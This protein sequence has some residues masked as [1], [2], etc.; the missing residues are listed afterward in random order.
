MLLNALDRLDARRTARDEV[1]RAE[2]EIGGLAD[3]GLTWRVTQ[4]ARARQ[5]ADHP[6]LSHDSDLGEDREAL[7]G[8][9]AEALKNEI[10]RKPGRR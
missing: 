8:Q 2:A 10:W 6:S 3:E 5:H 4:S 7:A 9:L 1:A